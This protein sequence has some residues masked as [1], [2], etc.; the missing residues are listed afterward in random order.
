MENVLLDVQLELPS[1]RDSVQVAEKYVYDLKDLISISDEK[2]YNIL[3]TVTEAVNN[4]IMHGNKYD[5]DKKVVFI[6]QACNCEVCITIMDQG[7]GFDPNSL[8]DPLRT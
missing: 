2:F 1:R 4:G 7:D 5:N 6:M 8:G 3:I